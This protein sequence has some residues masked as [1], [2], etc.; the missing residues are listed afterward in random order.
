MMPQGHDEDSVL[1]EDSISPGI[2]MI[3]EDNV[4]SEVR[5]N[6]I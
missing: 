2:V 6:E 4:T 5:R 1:D 3:W